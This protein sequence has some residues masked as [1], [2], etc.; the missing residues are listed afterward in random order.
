MAATAVTFE[1]IMFTIIQ[2]TQD[3]FKAYMD[4]DV[5]A[6]RFEKEVQPVEADVIGIVG[7][8]GERVGYIIFAADSKTAVKFAQRFLMDEN[9]DL[10]TIRDAVGEVANNIAGQFKSKYSQEYGK[11]SL[12]LPLIMSGMVV[13]LPAGGQNPAADSGEQ[14]VQVQGNGV[15]IPFKTF[16]EDF[17][18]RVMVFM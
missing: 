17:Q 3:T 4:L 2:A 1:E 15:I 7:V 5:F 14:S 18:F 16:D 10:N 6:G 11:I 12:G 9:P 8:A 13:P